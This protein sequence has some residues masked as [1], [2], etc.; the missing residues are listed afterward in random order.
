[1][2][3]V[4]LILPD[5]HAS[6]GNQVAVALGHDIAPG[7]TY[8]VPLSADGSEPYT[9]YGARAQASPGFVVMLD[10]ATT[11][12]VPP[13]TDQALADAALAMRTAYPD[14]VAA[15]IYDVRNTEEVSD[16]WSDVLAANGLQ[17]VMPSG[18]IWG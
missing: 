17:T 14:T 15:L 9:H 4:V 18:G 16:H 12:N 5:E 2:M 13:G 6:T 11:G 7:Q 10:I 8:S 3:S 1:M